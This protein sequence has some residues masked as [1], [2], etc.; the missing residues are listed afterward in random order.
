MS[1]DE[2]DL[3][4]HSATE[5]HIKAL[6]ITWGLTRKQVL[7]HLVAFCE[8]DEEAAVYACVPAKPRK[9]SRRVIESASP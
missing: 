8:N 9:R 3:R 2:R 5:I 6:R 4:M 1:E 7:E